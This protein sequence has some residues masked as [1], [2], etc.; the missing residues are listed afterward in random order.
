MNQNKPIKQNSKDARLQNPPREE[1]QPWIKPT[2][3]RM[4]LKEAMTSSFTFPTYNN[5]GTIY[6]S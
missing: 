1:R 6:Y 4:T 5:D 2:F 3:E